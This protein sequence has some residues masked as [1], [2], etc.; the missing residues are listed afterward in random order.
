ME[1]RGIE[2]GKVTLI[3]RWVARGWSL[4]SIGF[5]LLIFVGEFLFPHA[6]ASFTFRD[7]VLLFFFPFGTCVGMI[8]ALRWQGLGGAITVGSLLAFY[9][10]LR[11][12]EGRFPRGPFFVLVAGPGFLF[13][14]LWAIALAQKRGRA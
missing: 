12:M 1:D 10:A 11:I 8:L 13:L 6:P 2:P 7:L 5:L 9:A 14:A 4:A 3:I